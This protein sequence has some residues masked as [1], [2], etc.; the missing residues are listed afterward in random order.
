MKKIEILVTLILMTAIPAGALNS[1]EIDEAIKLAYNF[2]FSTSEKV[3]DD[4]QRRN[5]VELPGDMGRIVYTVQLLSQNPM[6]QN[7]D[8]MYD[9]LKNTKKKVTSDLKNGENDLLHFYQCF[10]HYYYMKSYA[11]EDR[12][13]KTL[14]HAMKARKLTVELMDRIDD[15]PDLYFIIGDQNYTTSLVPEYLKPLLKALKFTPDRYGGYEFIRLAIEKAEFTRYEAALM[16][17]ASSLYVERDYVNSYKTSELFI[18]QFPGNLS[19]RFFIIDLQ[20]HKGNIEEAEQLMD[21]ARDD[22]DAGRLK[23]KWIPRYIQMTGNISNFKGD[24]RKAIDLYKQAMEFSDI[25]GYTATETSLEIGKL[26]DIIG[27]RKEAVKAYKECEKGN[28]LELHKEEAR[29]LQRSPYTENRG[30]Y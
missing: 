11:L 14:K 7:F 29:V 21:G 23:G 19:V 30:S 15:F 28:G 18:Q 6:E 1:P 20:L 22:F 4:Y 13:F 9:H 24:Y 5:P 10:I 16:Y 12:W 3:L 26:Y 8:R 27:D 25:S 17:I 2:Q